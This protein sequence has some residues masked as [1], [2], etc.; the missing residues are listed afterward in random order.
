[1]TK[2]RLTSSTDCDA[3]T[4]EKHQAKPRDMDDIARVPL[5]QPLT[6]RVTGRLGIS[7]RGRRWR[8]RGEY[9]PR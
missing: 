7:G 1:M 5:P 2:L 4:E 6:K 9:A 8:H 3:K